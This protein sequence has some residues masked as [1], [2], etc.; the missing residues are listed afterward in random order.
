[1]TPRAASR[2]AE[3]A[4]SPQSAKEAALFTSTSSRPGSRRTAPAAIG[5][6]LVV[7]HV[8]GDGAHVGAARR[9][10]CGGLRG[11]RRVAGREEDGHALRGEET[12]HRQTDPPC[13]TRHQCD[14]TVHGRDL[15]RRSPPRQGDPA[16]ARQAAEGS[17]ESC[18]GSS[19]AVGG[20][21]SEQGVQC[22]DR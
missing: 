13:A 9:Q 19:A 21:Q 11:A 22:A 3:D 17:A 8:E 14:P 7:G 20:R 5:D 10:R 18:A 2:S 4:V 12:A 15:T 6:A 1:M 16:G